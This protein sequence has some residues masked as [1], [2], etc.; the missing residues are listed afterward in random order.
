[1]E[2]L[3]V[4]KISQNL[5][6]GNFLYSVLRYNSKV[7]QHRGCSIFFSPRDRELLGLEWGIIR[8]VSNTIFLIKIPLSD[9]NIPKGRTQCDAL[10]D[11][12]E[13]KNSSNSLLDHA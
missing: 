12:K 13:V 2:K 7:S 4:A 8:Q 10:L 11:E 6:D 5:A 9:V 3:N 1:M